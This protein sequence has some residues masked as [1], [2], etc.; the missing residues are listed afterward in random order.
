MTGRPEVLREN[1]DILDDGPAQ[2]LLDANELRAAVLSLLPS[3]PFDLIMTHGLRAEYTRHPE[4][5]WCRRPCGAPER[6][7]RGHVESAVEKDG[8]IWFKPDAVADVGYW[9][10]MPHLVL[11][12][13]HF[14]ILPVLWLVAHGYIAWRPGGQHS[15][16]P[17]PCFCMPRNASQSAGRRSFTR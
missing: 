3:G 12:P 10:M 5:H 6:P 17:R 1:L 13:Q 11:H 15:P 7:R 2:A 16:G 8:T 4:G 14:G 9:G